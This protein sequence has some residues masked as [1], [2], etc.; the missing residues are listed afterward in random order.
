MKYA[1]LKEHHDYFNANQAIEFEELLSPKQ[2]SKLNAG[3]NQ[4]L[5]L[6]LK[7]P[8]I[9]NIKDK[10]ERLFMA[11]RD[12]WRDDQDVKNIICHKD[13]AFIASSLIAI[14]SLRIAYD[15]FIA[16]SDISISVVDSMEFTTYSHLFT[17]NYLLSEI[18]S[19]SNL[20]CGV[21]IALT[22][23]PAL[24]NKEENKTSL[25]E[26]MVSPKPL[27]LFPEKSGNG[28]F[29]SSKFPLHLPKLRLQSG[30]HFLLIAYAHPISLYIHNEKDPHNHALKR[31]DYQLGSR[32]SSQYHPILI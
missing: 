4:I 16:A 18:S 13:L 3:L 23:N 7:H 29:F 27:S 6:R 25:E 10:A 9:Y 21:V 26:Q 22:D 11:G 20:L 5:S 31:F 24:A 12:L 15:Q 17:Q 14:P 8:S 30:Q 28:V 2:L 1:L 32:L 19:I